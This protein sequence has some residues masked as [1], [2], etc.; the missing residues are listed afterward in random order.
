MER[1]PSY[2]MFT[3]SSAVFPFPVSFAKANIT[4]PNPV[5]ADLASPVVLVY[6]EIFARSSSNEIPSSA[7][8]PTC[9]PKDSA[10]SDDSN[11]PV[12]TA[13]PNA[14]IADVAVIVSFPYAFCAA[15]ATFARSV[16]SP[17]PSA[18]PLFTVVK[19][20]SALTPRK[21]ADVKK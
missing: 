5:V 16:D 7:A 1:K 14:S 12:L 17:S 10:S 18:T 13:I 3:L 4:P 11:I 2:D 21:P 20:S 15:A 9:V 6:V 8:I 19:V